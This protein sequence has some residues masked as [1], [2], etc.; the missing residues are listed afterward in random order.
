VEDKSEANIRQCYRF[1]RSLPYQSADD[2]Q[3]LVDLELIAITERK[4]VEGTDG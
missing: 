2:I 1:L 3:R 4:M